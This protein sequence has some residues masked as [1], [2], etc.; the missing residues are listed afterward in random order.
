MEKSWTNFDPNKDWDREIR[1]YPIFLCF[2]WNRSLKSLRMFFIIR[3]GNRFESLEMDHFYCTYSSPTTW[4]YLAGPPWK[5]PTPWWIVWTT[6]VA[7]PNKEWTQPS[8]NFFF[9]PNVSR[10]HISDVC[11]LTR[12]EATGD[13]GKYLGVPL[14]TKRVT[15]AM[16]HGLVVRVQKILSSWKANQLSLAGRQVLVQSVSSTLASHAMQSVKL[17]AGVCESI[18]RAQ[19]QFLWGKSDAGEKT[20]LVKWETVCRP[21]D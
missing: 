19:R 14:Q 10:E 11:R 2:V 16:L 5:T 17:P 18:D 4:F 8:L 1:F 9:S 12:M 6:F 21:K 7:Y 13:L 15:K 3:N 20:P